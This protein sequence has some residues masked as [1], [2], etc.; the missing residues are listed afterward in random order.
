MNLIGAD[1]PFAIL[2]DAN[3]NGANL[4]AA[5]LQGAILR[6]TVLQGADLSSATVH[7]DQLA[8]ARS[9]L[10]ATMPD[11]LVYDGRLNLPGDLALLEASQSE[12]QDPEVLAAFYGVPTTA[13]LAGQEWL[14]TNGPMFSLAKNRCDRPTE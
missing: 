1:L 4:N 13:Y 7:W 8:Q 5:N 6:C 2:A 10:G 12:I 9:L 11:G 3:L 14:S